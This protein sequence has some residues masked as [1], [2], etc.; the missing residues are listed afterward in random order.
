MSSISVQAAVQPPQ[1]EQQETQGLN[2][3]KA[4]TKPIMQQSHVG[5]MPFSTPNAKTALGLTAQAEDGETVTQENCTGKIGW[6]HSA[7]GEGGEE[8]GLQVSKPANEEED[9]IG[10]IEE[11]LRTKMEVNS[12]IVTNII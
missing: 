8:S 11:D 7:W 1:Q 6:A 12:L 2:K 5:N 3:R 10:L 4:N 9:D